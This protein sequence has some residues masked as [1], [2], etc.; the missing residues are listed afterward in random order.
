M[1]EAPTPQLS[2]AP[3]V[4]SPTPSSERGSL[5]WIV[6]SIIFFGTTVF[7]AYQYWQLTHAT[8]TVS[9]EDCLKAPGSI[10]QESYPATCVTKDGNRFTQPLTDEEKKKL[11]PPAV[12]Q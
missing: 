4:P 7:F 3:P 12:S 5:F 9:Y 11:E 10:V 1:E 6:L 2:Q 8:P